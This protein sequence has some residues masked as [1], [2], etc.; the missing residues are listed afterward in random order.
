MQVI[1]YPVYRKI[2]DKI[3]I[4]YAARILERADELAKEK[5]TFNKTE[6][7]HKTFKNISIIRCFYNQK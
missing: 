1:A 4:K 5:N 7:Y 3:K 6:T 2:F